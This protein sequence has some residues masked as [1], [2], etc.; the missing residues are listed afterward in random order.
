VSGVPRETLLAQRE[1]FRALQAELGSGFTLLHGGELNIGPAGGR[2]YDLDLRRA[3]DGC[4]PSLHDPFELDRA[5][6]TKRVV[7][8]M[9]DPAVRMIGH[10]S[11]R[12]IGGGGPRTGAIPAH[13]AAG[14]EDGD[15]T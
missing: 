10:L 1:R 2:G 12:M 15:G 6:Q 13:R 9:Q 14:A 3:S 11:A 4:L 7:T 5:A 8:A